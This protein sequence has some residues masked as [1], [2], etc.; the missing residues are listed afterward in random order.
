MRYL[1]SMLPREA[2]HNCKPS[3]AQYS[4][5]CYLWY[6]SH[7]A[8][9]ISAAF[10]LVLFALRLL[11]KTSSLTSRDDICRGISGNLLMV[12]IF[13]KPHKFSAAGRVARAVQESTT[14]PSLSPFRGIGH[15]AGFYER[16]SKQIGARPTV[17]WDCP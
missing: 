10:A 12:L 4:S 2:V 1:L 6:G 11:L 14:P 16:A 7:S 17:N 8:I 13:Y 9:Y 5:L 3:A 15:C